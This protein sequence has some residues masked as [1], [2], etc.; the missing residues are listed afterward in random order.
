MS[1]RNVYEK[2]DAFWS[3]RFCSIVR[4]YALWTV[5]LFLA[6]LFT[7]LFIMCFIHFLKDNH[8]NYPPIVDN[9]LQDFSTTKSIYFLLS[10]YFL[11]WTLAYV[12]IITSTTIPWRSEEKPGRMLIVIL[13]FLIGIISFLLCTI[14]RLYSPWISNFIEGKIFTYCVQVSALITISVGGTCAGVLIGT[15]ACCSRRRQ[16]IPSCCTSNNISGCPDHRESRCRSFLCRILKPIGLG[17]TGPLNK[18]SFS[19]PCYNNH[20][21]VEFTAITEN[22]S[23]EDSTAAVPV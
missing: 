13:F 7:L 8:H 2:L 10:V 14:D 16:A 19:N 4:T 12:G 3:S 17:H 11:L 20:Y 18:F 22:R 1:L 15:R 23:G 21:N 9:D 5:A 6:A